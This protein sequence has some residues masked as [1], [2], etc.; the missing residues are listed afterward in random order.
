MIF[1]TLRLKNLYCFKDTVIDFTYLEQSKDT[2]LN[3]NPLEGFPEIRFK[4]INLLMG[5]NASG[6]TSLAKVMYGIN[7]FLSGGS[8]EYVKEGID[9]SK[10]L[11]SIEV[12]YITPSTSEVHHL[13]VEVCSDGITKEVHRKQPLIASKSL[14]NTIEDVCTAEPAFCYDLEHTIPY[15]EFKSIG[16]ATGRLELNTTDSNYHYLVNGNKVHSSR[17]AQKNVRLYKKILRCFDSSI[18]NVLP[19]ENAESDY[20]IQFENGNTVTVK[21]GIVAKDEGQY[22]SKGTK[23][24][25]PVVLLVSSLLSSKSLS[26]AF[27]MDGG[28]GY[29]HPL[30]ERAILDVV[31]ENLNPYSQFFYTTHTY[32]SLK[33]SIP[34]GNFTF[35]QKGDGVKTT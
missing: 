6:K 34:D 29:A 2:V 35:F 23:E 1:L 21:E 28:M 32:E 5:A 27:F 25:V 10:G 19:V 18:A 14:V 13:E 12:V 7:S 20:V 33:H 4:R 30:L 9:S 24:A 15:P 8:L 26:T 17:P 31:F 22:L 3:N 11:G 16:I